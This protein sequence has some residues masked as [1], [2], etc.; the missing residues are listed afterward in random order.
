MN[1]D[2]ALR[3]GYIQ[4]SEE[5]CENSGHPALIDYYHFRQNQLLRAK[6]EHVRTAA[7]YG[8]PI[9]TS[10]EV[11]METGRTSSSENKLIKNSMALQ[12]PPRKGGV[13]ECFVARP[14]CT[15]IVADFGQ[16]E[17]VSLAQVTYS[18]F[19]YSKMREVLNANRDLHVDFGRQILGTR[20]GR[21]IAYDEAWTL[22]VSK[23]PEMKD[24]RQC[25]KSC[26]FG[27]SG[28]LGWASLQSYAKKAWGV[29]LTGEQAKQL[30]ID[31]L[32]HF[33][34]M[35]AYFDWIG[36]LTEDGRGDI[37]QF[38]SQRW[39][40][41]CYFTQAANS[42]FQA[43]TADAAK[44]AMFEVSRYCYTVRS[45]A[46]YGCRPVLFVHD[47]IITEA[48][49]EQAAEAAKEKEKIMVETYRRFTPDVV[50]TA[51]AFLTERWSKDAEA[52]FDERGRLIPWNPPE[53]EDEHEEKELLAA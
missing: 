9:Q 28:G 7:T 42:F 27:L 30:K 4:T 43:L 25:A 13:R 41:K 2:Q 29:N 44:A 11:L 20:W 26:N 47:E 36:R 32:R 51:G 48:P 14:G 49:I 12:N 24:M 5:W 1:K 50:I 21:N 18:A 34:E 45:S 6:L 38:M 15:L 31:W 53:E 23:N 16:A 39:R 40:G 52:V 3:A 37:Q 17:L 8:L 33:S 35:R 10:F 19:G 46:L 22:H